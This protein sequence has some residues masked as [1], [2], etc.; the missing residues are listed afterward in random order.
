[1][2]CFDVVDA[3]LA[4]ADDEW[5]G[6]LA[7]HQS[8]LTLD[9]VAALK[10]RSDELIK[11]DTPQAERI[12]RAAYAVA[13]RLVD[14]PFAMPLAHWARGNW[15]AYV[16]PEQAVRCYRAALPIY[17]Q[18]GDYLA[19]GRLHSNL[20]GV[21]ATL[22]Q[23]R[24][25]DRSYEQAK[26]YLDWVG[27]D[28]ISYRLDLDLNYGFLL[29]EQGRYKEALAVNEGVIALASRYDTAAMIE[30][31]TE[32][33]I[34][35]AF[36][37]A[38]TGRIRESETILLDSR[39][40]LQAMTPPPM[41]T[42]ARIDLN[43]GV[44]YSAVGRLAEAFAAFKRALAGFQTVAM[45]YAAT[46]LYE[47]DL[48]AQLGA[49]RAARRAY[50]EARWVFG[51]A[52][53]QQYAARAS[54][55]GANVRR[56]LD[57]SDTQIDTMLA[58]ALDQFSALN[59]SLEAADT[60]L[61]LARL[62]LLRNQPDRAREW[63]V[64]DLPPD[65]SPELL[66]KR[67][68]LEGRLAAA[69]GHRETAIVKWQQAL[70]QSRVADLIWWQRTIHAELGRV[71]ERDAIE[72]A[73]EHLATAAQIDDA[74]RAELS[75]EELIADFQDRRND[76]LPV[77]ARLAAR[78]GW[79]EHALRAMWRAK[80]SAIAEL[81]ARRT[82]QGVPFDAPATDDLYQRIVTLRWEA[83]YYRYHG[84]DAKADELRSV[85]VQLEAQRYR[86]RLH[87][88]AP[89]SG[90]MTSAAVE[91]SA[92]AARMDADLLIEYLRCDDDL[93]ACCLDRDGRVTTTWLG[94]V[95]AVSD[96]LQK[97][98][99]RNL[100]VLSLPS[101]QHAALISTTLPV[102]RQLYDLLIAPLPLPPAG[103]LLIAPCAPLHYV[104]FAALWDG[105]HYLGERYLI[106]QIPSGVLLN[107]PVPAGEP[108]PPLAIGASA[109]GELD[110]VAQE[111]AAVKE[112]LPDARISVDDPAAADMLRTL[113][114]AP[115][116]LHLSA[117]TELGAEA[118]IFAGLQLAGRMFT[119]A[120]C[121]NLNLA[122]TELVVLSGCTTAH[123]IESG[124]ALLALQSALLIAGARRIMVSLWP[125]NDAA[126]A[127]LM[128]RFYQALSAD[129]SPPEALRTAQQALR[130]DPA[131][132][133][134]AL[135]AAFA[136]VRRG[137]VC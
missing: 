110:A 98:V 100:K 66:V 101:R 25:A 113:T 117:H 133:H 59:L 92:I 43:L 2:M 96:T 53:L 115:R 85:L 36:I 71:L 9:V 124:G 68:W 47:A 127:T 1:M 35:Q 13:Q 11:T 74:L 67:L 104:P 32:A 116:I 109:E 51:E 7:Q 126:T 64:A 58:H 61:E 27:D 95:V 137:I 8:S 105:D 39:Q 80:G 37:F 30:A 56:D 118:T 60:R 129:Q 106:E 20:L 18:K 42:L 44:Y 122:G 97:L 112:A 26:S 99:T 123:G 119:I 111:I 49:L 79:H 125:I 15:A 83:A 31:R 72:A 102:L 121:Y 24:A 69:Q 52:G 57:P 28:A 114:Q 93:L 77:F 38:C 23:F 87:A 65:A 22:G 40:T 12:T 6:W 34:N 41:L 62:A 45:D 70:A 19:I 3:L 54:L 63:L 94:S 50:D 21:Y 10:R 132:A 73:A 86:L 5:E 136:V 14:E 76:V 131:F 90:A 91:P 120:D 4:L 88:M 17:E 130:A 128:R 48:L 81:M 75:V 103:T 82:G 89:T 29:L 55:A 78:Q 46:L 84:N 16:D 134:P 33:R 107:I 108:G 135:W